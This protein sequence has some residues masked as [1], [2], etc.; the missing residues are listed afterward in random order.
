[1]EITD[2]AVEVKVED[3]KP[4]PFSLSSL[5][6]L[7]ASNWPLEVVIKTGWLV[8]LR[9]RLICQMEVFPYWSRCRLPFYA[10]LGRDL[11][12]LSLRSDQSAKKSTKDSLSWPYGENWMLGSPD[13][14]L[15]FCVV[16]A[17]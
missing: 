8:K 12:T 14:S 15:S 4:L 9:G 11:P 3:V 6:L 16:A 1:M 10:D 17:I 13:A 2:C 7:L 5:S